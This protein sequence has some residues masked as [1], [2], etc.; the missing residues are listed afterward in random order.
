MTHAY[1]LHEFFL[2]EVPNLTNKIVL[3]CGCGHGVWGYLVCSEKNGDKAYLVGFDLNKTYVKYCKWHRVYNDVVLADARY[4]PFRRKSID[5]VLAAEIVE[6][7]EKKDGNIFLDE[8]EGLCREVTIVS[9]PNGP[10]PAGHLANESPLELHR[11]VWE[12]SDFTRRR[13]K[14]RGIGLKHSWIFYRRG[15]RRS[16]YSFIFG[17]FRY[18]F[19]PLAYIFPGIS[20][21]LIA[22]KK[23]S[24]AELEY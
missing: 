20:G 1:Q 23:F 11:A 24:R 12:V 21:I 17:F 18:T 3:D 16:V 4:L 9:T 14:V 7:L 5:V 10:A 8:V 6:H 2:S 13:Y 22:T 19:T 15:R